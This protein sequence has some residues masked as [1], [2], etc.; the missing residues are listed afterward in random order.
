MSR[1]ANES[2]KNTGS[3]AIL[4]PPARDMGKIVIK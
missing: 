4:T 2:T 3:D 1:I